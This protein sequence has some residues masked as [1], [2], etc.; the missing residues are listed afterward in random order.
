MSATLLTFARRQAG[1]DNEERAL[2]ARLERLLMGAGLA[3][4]V[5][6]GETDEGDPWAAFCNAHTGD[7][8]VHIARLDGYYLVEAGVLGRAIE[9][10]SLAHCS[11][12]FFAEAV[13]V[14]PE[15]RQGAG[16]YLHPSAMLAGMLLSIMLYA[17]MYGPRPE[18]ATEEDAAAADGAT[19][20]IDALIAAAEAREGSD[21]AAATD[22]ER[23][24]DAEEIAFEAEMAGEAHAAAAAKLRQIVQSVSQ[25][26]AAEAGRERAADSG[27][28]FQAWVLLHSVAM[29]AALGIADEGQLRGALDGL[30]GEEALAGA[31]QGDAIWEQ[32]MAAAAAG[33][34]LEARAGHAAA[35]MAENGEHRQDAAYANGDGLTLAEGDPFGFAFASLEDLLAFAPAESGTDALPGSLDAAWRPSFETGLETG[36]DASF[37]AG[38]FAGSVFPGGVF[39]GGLATAFGGLASFDTSFGA[40]PESGRAE[41]APASPAAVAESVAGLAPVALPVSRVEPA[42]ESAAITSGELTFALRDL[43]AELTAGP[44]GPTLLQLAGL[45]LDDAPMAEAPVVVFVPAFET[46][47]PAEYGLARRDAPSSVSVLDQFAFV[48]TDDT[49][50]LIPASALTGTATA[51]QPL[52]Y[53]IARDPFFALLRDAESRGGTTDPS[54]LETRLID[55]DVV[56]IDPRSEGLAAADLVTVSVDYAD[57]SSAILVTALETFDDW[58]V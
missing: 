32:G 13:L 20:D 26:V 29:I 43:A 11:E 12:R 6:L 42:A 16:L 22:A 52:H 34:A 7:V 50:D 41:K 45:S 49:A 27:Q 1:W 19:I 18:I 37:G 36:V 39:P 47:A 46:R 25:F 44:S 57:S 30:E 17:Q 33:L 28:P 56:L 9:G 15:Q 40:A 58:L 21:E 31:L 38:W 24:A 8:V 23:G 55:G 35:P 14:A 3:V 5:E 4:E 48:A 51:T 54:R 2:I 10:R 53:S